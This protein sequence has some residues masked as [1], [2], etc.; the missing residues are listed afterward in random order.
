MS[1]EAAQWAKGAFADQNQTVHFEY[2]I[3]AAHVGAS[4]VTAAS[5]FDLSRI[6]DGD[7]AYSALDGGSAENRVVVE[8]IFSG[9]NWRPGQVLW[10]R[11]RFP[12]Y[13]GNTADHAMAIHA[14]SLAAIPEPSAFAATLGLFGLGAAACRRRRG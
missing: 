10:L 7:G 1:Y 12:N 6:N 2:A 8:G 14:F 11:W 9:I 5:A 4:G 13:N 3:G